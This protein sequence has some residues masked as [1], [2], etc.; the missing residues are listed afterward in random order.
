MH[1]VVALHEDALIILL[2]ACFAIVCKGDFLGKIT[3]SCRSH[4]EQENSVVVAS[5]ILGHLTNVKNHFYV[6]LFFFQSAGDQWL[7]KDHFD[8]HAMISAG[9]D[10]SGLA[11]LIWSRFKRKV[12]SLQVESA[13]CSRAF[14]LSCIFLIFD[15]FI[16]PLHPPRPS[17]WKTTFSCSTHRYLPDPLDP[18]IWLLMICRCSFCPCHVPFAFFHLFISFR[19]Y[20]RPL[21]RSPRAATACKPR[22]THRF[23]SSTLG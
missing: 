22:R 4:F 14:F 10:E 11:Q 12:L 16:S 19:M 23:P 20:P 7:G 18:A 9:E 1:L 17:L 21:Q 8:A 3:T 6:F 5:L 13:S 2:L 15:I